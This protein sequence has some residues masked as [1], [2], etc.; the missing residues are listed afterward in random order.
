MLRRYERFLQRKGYDTE[1][2]RN[3]AFNRIQIERTFEKV[4]K[5]RDAKNKI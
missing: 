4:K 3:N 5:K 2:L 1:R